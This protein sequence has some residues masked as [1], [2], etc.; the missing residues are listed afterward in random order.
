MIPNIQNNGLHYRMCHYAIEI[1]IHSDKKLT[2]QIVLAFNQDA[3][4]FNV[5]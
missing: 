4:S 3:N 5:L 1:V 2:K